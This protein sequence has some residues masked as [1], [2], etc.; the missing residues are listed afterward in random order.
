MISLRGS[1]RPVTDRTDTDDAGSS[2]QTEPE[3]LSAFRCR[4]QWPERFS[5]WLLCVFSDRHQIS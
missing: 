5:R 2:S 3:K 4:V 1:D